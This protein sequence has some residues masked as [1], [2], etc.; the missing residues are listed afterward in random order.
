MTAATNLA[1]LEPKDLV[2]GG[3]SIHYYTGGEGEPLLLLHGLG[4]RVRELGRAAAGSARSA[5][6]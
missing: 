5:I 1:G 3:V 6:A 2:T 4:R